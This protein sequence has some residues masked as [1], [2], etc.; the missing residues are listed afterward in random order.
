MK[1]VFDI[2]HEHFVRL[3]QEFVH[4]ANICI[5][6][7]DKCVFELF[8]SF[9]A[10]FPA[11]PDVSF[12]HRRVL[13]EN[14]LRFLLCTHVSALV[15]ELVCASVCLCSRSHPSCSVACL[16]GGILVS[17]ESECVYFVTGNVLC[18]MCVFCVRVCAYLTVLQTPPSAS[19]QFKNLKAGSQNHWYH[20]YLFVLQAV[21][22]AT[23]LIM[24][25]RCFAFCSIMPS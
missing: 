17:L 21:S 11:L 22:R 1:S 5:I 16:I 12:P 2:L 15:S 3:T 9:S 4:G 19:P 14:L 7:T 23:S 20:L 6:S 8:A 13:N 24:R 25:L 18:R 10:R